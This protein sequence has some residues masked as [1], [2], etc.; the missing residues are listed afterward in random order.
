ML[1]TLMVQ[2]I[3]LHPHAFWCQ[4]L[5]TESL[6]TRKILS[7]TSEVGILVVH[8]SIEQSTAEACNNTVSYASYPTQS[9]Q[10]A[11]QHIPLTMPA[12]R[13]HTIRL[14]CQ[15]CFMRVLPGCRNVE[16]SDGQRHPVL[17]SVGLCCR[18]QGEKIN[19]TMAEGGEEEEGVASSPSFTARAESKAWDIFTLAQCRMMS[20]LP[21]ALATL[22]HGYS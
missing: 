11:G 16:L 21:C 20:R 2:S 7:S 12:Y 17:L 19:G 3:V 18:L 6:E 15:L 10:P 9:I 1:Y 13:T 5:H 14:Y 4:L 22:L 8:R